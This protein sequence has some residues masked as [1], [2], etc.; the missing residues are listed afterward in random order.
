MAIRNEPW[1]DEQNRQEALEAHMALFPSCK[2]CKH[3]L[4]NDDTVIRIG[5]DYYCDCCAEIM[6]NE[7]MREAE[8]ID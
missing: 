1:Q 6:T 2:I 3:C 8:D 4:M 5:N 7:E